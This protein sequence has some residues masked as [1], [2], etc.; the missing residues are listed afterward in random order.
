M[1]RWLNVH[2]TTVLDQRFFYTLRDV[3]FYLE[4]VDKGVAEYRRLALFA[5]LQAITVTDSENLKDY[6]TGKIDTCPQLDAA[7][8]AESIAAAGYFYK[9]LNFQ[10]NH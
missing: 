1:I 10:T 2:F 5:K 3:I 6:L 4:R 8:A 9:F 7:K